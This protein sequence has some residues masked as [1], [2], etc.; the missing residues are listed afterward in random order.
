[1]LSFYVYVLP[2][3]VL[4][5][6]HD[7]VPSPMPDENFESAR[8]EVMDGCHLTYRCWEPELYSLQ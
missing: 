6:L 2:T 5:T 3:Y 7:A 1:M 4:S 8:T